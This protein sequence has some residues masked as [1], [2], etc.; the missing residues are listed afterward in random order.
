MFR[1]SA[2][3]LKLLITSIILLFFLQEVIIHIY[4]VSEPYPALRM[5]PFTGNSM[6]EEGFFQTTSV[7]VK[8]YFADG[9][10]LVITPNEFFYDAPNS[11]LWSLTGNFR[12]V[13]KTKGKPAYH[14]YEMLKPIIPGFFI[15]RQRGLYEIQHHSET[16]Q[17]LRKQ[18]QKI[19]PG[20][21]PDKISFHWYKGLYNPDNLLNRQRQL[22]DTTTI[23]FK[24]G[25]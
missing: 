11:H 4:G 16:L 3:R 12:P 25:K 10:Q 6:N 18:I 5:P 20:K 22:I 2:S 23:Y 21:S 19:S 15:S 14:Q 8:I 17:W 9:E 1:L 24:N 7:D 13:D